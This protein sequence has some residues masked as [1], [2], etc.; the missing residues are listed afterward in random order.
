[1]KLLIEWTNGSMVLDPGVVYI[2]GRDQSSDI[3][4]DHS[5]V[6]R[7]HLRIEYLENQWVAK[8]LNSSNG[9]FQGQK[10]IVFV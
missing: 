3:H 7:S 6:S 1:M 8:D 9:T 5:R 2:V 10:A 4:I